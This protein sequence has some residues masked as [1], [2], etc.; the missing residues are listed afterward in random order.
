MEEVCSGSEEFD[1]RHITWSAKSHWVEFTVTETY[2]FDEVETFVTGSIKWDGCSNWDF[3]TGDCMKHFCGRCGAMGL[4]RL[5]DRLYTIAQENMPE[6][7]KTNLY[8]GYP[9]GHQ[10]S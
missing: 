6:V 1:G 7:D 3:N 5:M 10:V 2:N 8:D 4:G 9:R